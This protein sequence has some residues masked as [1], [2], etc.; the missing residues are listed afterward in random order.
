MS[1]PTR[2]R[3]LGVVGAGATA[4]G[5]GVLA[6]AAAFGAETQRTTGSARESVVA[7]VADP[8]DDRVTLLVGEREVEV[9]DRDLVHRLLNAA[10]R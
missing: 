4:A 5:A 1:E 6:P 2:R 8:D 3:F 9:R 7:Y 10:G